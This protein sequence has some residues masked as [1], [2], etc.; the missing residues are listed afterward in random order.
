SAT[1][2]V[3]TEG[4]GCGF[5][6]LVGRLPAVR[7]VAEPSSASWYPACLGRLALE[8]QSAHS[9]CD[10]QLGRSSVLPA[11]AARAL[12]CGHGRGHAH[13]FLLCATVGFLA[14]PRGARRLGYVLVLFADGPD[15][16]RLADGW[17]SRSR[18]LAGAHA[19]R[20]ANRDHLFVVLGRVSDV[21][22]WLRPYR[23]LVWCADGCRSRAGLEGMER[24]SALA[25]ACLSDPT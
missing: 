13:D 23:H 10:Q 2:G 24:S 20:S 15:A 19:G 11:G 17:R 16:G 1:A 5:P 3:T 4:C 7:S 25:P 9:P 22:C 8:C 18:P 14:V 12:F 6:I 21:P